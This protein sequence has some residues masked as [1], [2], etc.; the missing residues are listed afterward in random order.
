MASALFPELAF[1]QTISRKA[2]LLER[3]WLEQAIIAL[4]GFLE[5]FFREFHFFRVLGT[6]A[7]LDNAGKKLC[8]QRLNTAMCAAMF[9]HGMPLFYIVR[10]EQ[11]AVR[12]MLGTSPACSAVLSGLLDAVP[13]RD[14]YAACDVAQIALPGALTHAA[15]LSG[16]PW[17]PFRN[18]A[19]VPIGPE[20]AREIDQLL[21]ALLPERWMYVVQAVPI[22]QENLVMWFETCARE[23]RSTKET[24]LQTEFQKADRMAAHYVDMLEKYL[25]RFRIG[26]QLGMWQTG[27]YF[28]AP[29]EHTVERGAAVLTSLY[30]AEKNALEPLRS[31]RCSASGAQSPFINLYNSRE[32]EQLISLPGGEYNGFRLVEQPA[33]DASFDPRGAKPIDIG[34][35]VSA[36][37]E[38][39]HRFSVSADDL[40]KHALVAGVTGSGKTNTVFNML[41]S[42]YAQC[43]I[44][45]LVIEPAKSEYRSL[46]RT[47]PDLCV[48]TLGE[49]RPEASSPFRINPF[50]FPKG[51]SLQT[52]IDYLKAVF[53][54]S[55]VMY[56]PMPYVLEDCLYRIYEDKGWNLVTSQNSRGETGAAFPTL[57]DLYNKIDPVVDVLG[58]ESRTALDIKAALKT[59]IN[60]LCV[61]G[62]GL[63]LNTPVSTPFHEIM[64]KPTVLELKSMGN[65]D[66]KVFMMGLVLT[67][68]Y[69]YYEAGNPSSKGLNHLTVIEEAHRLLKN[70]PTEKTS[71]DMANIKGKGVETFCNLLSE[72]RAYGEGILVAEQIPS[73]LAPDVVKNT[74]LKIMHRIVS[75]ED[76]DVMGDAMNMDAAQKRYAVSLETGEACAFSEG[77][78]RPVLIRTP[79]SVLKNNSGENTSFSDA[80]VH[81]R[82]REVFFKRHPELLQKMPACPSC[83]WFDKPACAVVDREVAELL[84]GDSAGEYGVQLLLPLLASPNTNDLDAF[85]RSVTDLPERLRYCFIARLISACIRTRE[86][87]YGWTFE[88]METLEKNAHAAISP[89]NHLNVLTSFIRM[90]AALQPYRFK[91]C[92]LMCP[93]KALIC[94][95]CNWFIKDPVLNNRIYEIVESGAAGED[96]FQ[97]LA[98]SLRE[99]FSEYVADAS[100]AVLDGISFCY[101]I[102]KLNDMRYSLVLQRRCL[103][104]FIQA[105]GR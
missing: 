85:F 99:F 58:Y 6:P 43:Q 95:E 26:R 53:N 87:F 51:I 103:E 54:A 93:A 37:R 97:D 20:P 64:Q 68:L 31:H 41:V 8:P 15:A 21:K 61:G 40:V 12:V 105:I 16:I 17:A 46:L 86:D 74:S 13:G 78:D 48:F 34:A 19:A 83:S 89:G 39:A 18:P 1:D 52:H 75:K 80:D 102:Q 91:L 32:I 59:R 47:I 90:D 70:V 72:I 28:L 9:A 67:A 49:E 60:N 22:G 10:C 84:A 101:L 71:E 7:E 4:P 100:D 23:I 76:R 56:A 57:L 81:F 63:M 65:E 14:L 24:C 88:A 55:F 94:H 2:A 11:G 50:A 82:M 69:E 62:K 25:G 27:V 96:V 104:K 98:L 38:G 79:L 35:I 30:A 29:D 42:L 92:E 36:G 3:S 44:P 77:L 73:K 45:F 33:F 5:K 66:E